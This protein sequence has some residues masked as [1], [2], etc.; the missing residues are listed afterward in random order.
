[1]TPRRVAAMWAE[2]LAGY[3]QDPAEHLTVTFPAPPDPG[4]V[5]VAGIRVQS[6]CAHHLLPISGT[7]TVAY[8]PGL[9]RRVVGLS[10]LARLVEGYSRRLQ[11]QERLGHQ[12]VDAI[13]R[14]L[15]PDGAACV[16]TA[17][18]GCMTLRG[19]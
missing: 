1:G 3:S 13:D 18:H 6:T 16:I 17:E 12:V 11:V 19:V 14:R 8:R 9:G 15:A 2:V 10:K 7:A 5:V 4:L